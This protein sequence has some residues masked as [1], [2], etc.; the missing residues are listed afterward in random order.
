[1][2]GT[3]IAGNWKMHGFAADLQQIRDIVAGLPA[4]GPRFEALICVPATLLSRASE[5]AFGSRLYIGGETCHPAVTGAFTGDIS[6]EMLKDAGAS[7]VIVGHSERRRYHGE[8]DEDV[9][10]QANAAIEAGLIPIICVGETL[11]QRESGATLEVISR[12]VAGSVPSGAWPDGIVIAY[13]P[14]WAIGTGRV[15]LPEQIGEVHLFIRNL[16]LERFGQAGAATRLLYGG[17]MSPANAEAILQV[18][19][20]NGGLVGGASLK[21]ADFLSICRI[22]CGTRAGT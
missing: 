11:D 13:E 14:V 7:H 22:A 20:V 18:A 21:A 3:L 17:S 16:L 1:M 9:Q 2:P 15:A 4:C 8:S 6:A 12:Q 19:H 5:A 10:A